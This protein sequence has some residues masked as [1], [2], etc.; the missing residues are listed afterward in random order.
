MCSLNASSPHQI[1]ANRRVYLLWSTMISFE[2]VGKPIAKQFRLA[3][4]STLKAPEKTKGRSPNTQTPIS[5]LTSQL[6]AC[7]NCKRPLPR[8]EIDFLVR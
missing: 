3:L 2:S 6:K 7:P 4:P 5:S 1:G 8:T